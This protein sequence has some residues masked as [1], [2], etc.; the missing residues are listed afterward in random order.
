QED[1][2]DLISIGTIGLIKA[3]NTFNNRK[4]AK[5]ATYAAKCIDNEILMQI[6]SSSRRK[7]EISLQDPIGQDS[8]GNEITLCDVIC[9]D[10]DT[11]IET[12]NAR[13]NAENLH[14][15]IGM[16]LT[17]REQTVIRLR[18]GIPD[19]RERTQLEVSCL[20]GISRSY[21]SRIEKKAMMKL[22]QGLGIR[23]S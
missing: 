7:G 11:V 19:G 22:A 14:E 15:G 20:M 6:R 16:F 18:Y 2:D 10:Q 13:I 23:I 4:G 9:K 1:M 5:L 17:P 21:I 8:E 12:V 3:I